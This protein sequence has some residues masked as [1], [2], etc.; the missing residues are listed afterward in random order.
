MKKIL[1]CT[2]ASDYARTVCR[3][4]GWLAGLTGASVDALYVSNLWEF[5][6]P[7]LLDL[8]GS[9]GASPY[10]GMTDALE[11]IEN[12]KAKLVEQAVRREMADAGVEMDKLAIQ[13]E[14]G[15][16]VDAVD[17]YETGD[18]PVDMV[19]LGKRGEGAEQA[20]DHLGGNLERVVR[21]ARQPCLVTNLEYREIKKAALAYDG[22]ASAQ[23]AV[24]WLIAETAL[25]D[26]ALSVVT[27]SDG[28]GDNESAHSLRVAEG[29]LEDA[30]ISAEAH[31]LT[32]D[33]EDEIAKFV[34]GNDIDLLIMGAYGHSRIRELLIG[35]TTTD[36]IRRCKIPVM[37]FR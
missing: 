36:L 9:I 7:F 37:L 2:D 18:S 34:E 14:T 32:G 33:T 17:A 26:I 15:L 5:E 29:R 19:V 8:G 25:R 28:H 24:D 12:K 23:K 6:L 16:L 27:V 13:H 20:K 4:T 22:S 1:A 3:Y 10:H 11:E 35:S 21:A 30:G 31:L